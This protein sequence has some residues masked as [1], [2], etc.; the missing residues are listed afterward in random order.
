MV[1]DIGDHADLQPVQRLVAMSGLTIMQPLMLMSF[2]MAMQM[3]PGQLTQGQQQ[4]QQDV[5]GELKARHGK[6]GS[7]MLI[8]P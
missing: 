1:G 6:K 2:D 3:R 7:T 5:E 8:T 4:A